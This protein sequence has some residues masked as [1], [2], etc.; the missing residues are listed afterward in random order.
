MELSVEEGG[1]IYPYKLLKIKAEK[2]TLWNCDLIPTSSKTLQNLFA[3]H[4]ST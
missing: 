4:A 2:K 1:L 3:L